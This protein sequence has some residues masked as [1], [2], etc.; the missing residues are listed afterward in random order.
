MWI[1]SLLENAVT[2]LASPSWANQKPI[3]NVIPGCTS[4]DFNL[5]H[6][7]GGRCQQWFTTQGDILPRHFLDL[8]VAERVDSTPVAPDAVANCTIKRLDIVHLKSEL[9]EQFRLLSAT[10]YTGQPCGYTVCQPLRLI[11]F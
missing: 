8:M 3:E 1:F 2:I 11:N 9:V 7:T 5:C 4:L 10:Q 6:D